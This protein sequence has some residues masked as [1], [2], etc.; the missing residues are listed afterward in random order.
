MKKKLYRIIGK[1]VWPCQHFTIPECWFREFG[2]CIKFI[3]MIV[4]RV[5][6][7]TLSP[8][9]NNSIRVANVSFEISVQIDFSVVTTFVNSECSVCVSWKLSLSFRLIACAYRCIHDCI[10]TALISSF[11]AS[12]LIGFHQYHA[13]DHLGPP[14]PP[15]NNSWDPSLSMRFA[16]RNVRH[17]CNSA[18]NY[19]KTWHRNAF[20]LA[21]P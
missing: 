13:T 20:T 12:K 19:T 10:L 15:H 16:T 4:Q 1:S 3:S 14:L 18:C 7:D 5:T 2:V 6:I 17:Q 9:F 11:R 21:G 8:P